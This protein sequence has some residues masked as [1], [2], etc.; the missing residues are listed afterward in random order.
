[1]Y[2]ERNSEVTD[3]S[4]RETTVEKTFIYLYTALLSLYLYHSTLKKDR[5]HHFEAITKCFSCHVGL[6]TQS[7]HKM[8]V[9]E[10]L[11]H[12]D[13]EN[14]AAVLAGRSKSSWDVYFSFLEERADKDMLSR[15][16][17]VPAKMNCHYLA[18]SVSV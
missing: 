17:E 15:G 5:N 3:K 4:A 7:T 6:V 13:T 11:I 16:M 2:G 18:S 12:R 8:G 1:M 14:S 9:M 10:R